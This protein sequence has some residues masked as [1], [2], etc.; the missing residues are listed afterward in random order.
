ME[1]G[2]TPMWSGQWPNCHG[3]QPSPCVIGAEAKLLWSLAWPLGDQG[4]SQIHTKPGPSPVWS[5]QRPNSCGPWSSICVIGQGTKFLWSLAQSLCDQGKGQ[6]PMEP[7]SVQPPQSLAPVLAGTWAEWINGGTRCSGT[8]SLASLALSPGTA[9]LAWP[10]TPCH[11]KTQQQQQQN[12]LQ[13]SRY[14]MSRAW[15]KVLTLDCKKSPS[16]KNVKAV[17]F[18]SLGHSFQNG[19]AS[20]VSCFFS[21]KVMRKWEHLFKMYYDG[22]STCICYILTWQECYSL[23][24]INLKQLYSVCVCVCVKSTKSSPNNKIFCYISISISFISI[25]M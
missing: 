5:G 24:W 22:C 11:Q 20:M 16:L 3:A 6:T 9:L 17:E 21:S 8:T 15:K 13:Q 14:E 10:P 23:F 12:R 1:P 18:D 4:R 2:P 7:G 25:S 19:L